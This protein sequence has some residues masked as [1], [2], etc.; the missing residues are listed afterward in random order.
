M[1]YLWHILKFLSPQKS[2]LCVNY[3]FLLYFKRAIVHSLAI[4]N[5]PI[6][7]NYYTQS[8]TLRASFVTLLSTLF[9]CIFRCIFQSS[10]ASFSLILFVIWTAS[11]D[12]GGGDPGEEWEPVGHRCSQGRGGGRGRPNVITHDKYC[13]VHQYISSSHLEFDSFCERYRSFA[14]STSEKML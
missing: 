3:K 11:W 12:W 1:I 10:S 2:Q 14:S 7:Q 5:A 8:S 6:L 9:W 13:T 4:R